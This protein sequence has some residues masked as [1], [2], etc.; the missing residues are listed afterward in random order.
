M[1]RELLY[2][3]SEESGEEF[4]MKKK[5]LVLCLFASMMMV[6]S[7]SLLD[8]TEFF[9]QK[10]Y[11]SVLVEMRGTNHTELIRGLREDV[12]VD[13]H[14]LE[15]FTFMVEDFFLSYR[16]E[17][18][19]FTLIGKDLDYPEFGTVYQ[20]RQ[21]RD[22]RNE[23]EVL[24]GMDS[25]LTQHADTGNVVEGLF[26]QDMLLVGTTSITDTHQDANGNL[27]NYD[28]LV[29]EI[30]NAKE[31]VRQMIAT[32]NEEGEVNFR[33]VYMF[34]FQN[35]NT[36]IRS[37]NTLRESLPT[38]DVY[39]PPYNLSNYRH[40]MGIIKNLLRLILLTFGASL[41][42]LIT[43]ES[44]LVEILTAF[45]SLPFFWILMS[46]IANYTA[47]YEVIRLGYD[48]W[49]IT[50]GILVGCLLIFISKQ[51]KDPETRK[52]WAFD[53]SIRRLKHRSIIK[54]FFG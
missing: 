48:A 42:L 33:L 32:G 47:R 10:N 38:F 22:L 18:N 7:L 50:G 53:N 29:M 35:W 27:V 28:V 3:F 52:R 39:T 5:N 14:D 45:F 12:L 13:V 16:T 54:M 34:F 26:G 30:N 11:L 2:F 43:W 21:G 31:A 9:S 51:M 36:M 46:L 23:D 8:L 15:G 44:G 40:K 17:S 19:G 20:T 24:L 41:I 37:S 49:W 1:E 4:G 25:P 6:A